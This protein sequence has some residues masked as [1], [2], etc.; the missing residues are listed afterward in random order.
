ME[1]FGMFQ[2]SKINRK[3]KEIKKKFLIV[4]LWGSERVLINTCV[5]ISNFI[6]YY[7]YMRSILIKMHNNSKM[8]LIIVSFDNK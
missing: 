7:I 1:L 3:K 4:F 5:W 6:I 8:W 2:S